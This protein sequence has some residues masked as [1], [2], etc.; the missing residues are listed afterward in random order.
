MCI[1]LGFKW[2]ILVGKYPDKLVIEFSKI[3]S[4]LTVQSLYNAM[5]GVHRL[6]SIGMYHVISEFCYKCINIL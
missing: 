1:A 6:E 4:C 5:Y 3:Y 2:Q